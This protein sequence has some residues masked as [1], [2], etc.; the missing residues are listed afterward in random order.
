[1]QKINDK[2]KWIV[3]DNLFNE[4]GYVRLINALDRLEQ[5]YE[6]VKVV[7]FAHEIIPDMDF[8]LDKKVL[9]MGSDSLIKAAQKKNWWPGAFT[10]ENFHHSVWKRELGDVLLNHDASVVRFEDVVPPEEDKSF[11]IRPAFDFKIFAGT[12]I[13]PESFISWRDKAV[14]Y[15]DTLNADTEVVVA[16]YREILQEY[17]FFVVNGMIV[18]ES[19]YKIGNRV[20]SNDAVDWD[21]GLFAVMVNARWQ[22]AYAYVMDV[23]R[24][25]DG[26]KVIEYNCINASGFYACDCLKIV[27]SLSALIENN[28]IGSIMGS[29]SAPHSDK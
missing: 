1:M 24:T 17:R 27:Q 21:V 11:F 25:K 2:M 16:P 19:S 6:I 15:G 28:P 10:N 3:Q 22:P 26:L 23:A 8:D 13:T 7:P 18:A 29:P 14:A 12:V 9:I 20:I 4:D 5:D